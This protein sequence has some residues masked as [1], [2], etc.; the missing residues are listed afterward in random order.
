LTAGGAEYKINTN[1]GEIAAWSGNMDFNFAVDFGFFEHHAHEVEQ[2]AGWL[3]YSSYKCL[4]YFWGEKVVSNRS[5][6]S[7]LTRM[8]R[9]V[10]IR[11]IRMPACRTGRYS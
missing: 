6:K 11:I 5:E 8:P 10:F 2:F 9:M 3:G 4:G 7:E 1:V